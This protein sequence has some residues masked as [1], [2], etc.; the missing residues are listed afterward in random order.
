MKK[1]L[2]TQRCLFKS[3]VH[4]PWS[5]VLFFLLAPGPLFAKNLIPAL[6]QEGLPKWEQPK[7]EKQE[8]PNGF[9]FYTL[10]DHALPLFRATLFIETG[11]A[12]APYQKSG[13]ADLTSTLLVTGGTRTKEPRALDEWVEER[14]ITV[15]SG[16]GRELTTLH[17]S[18]LAHQ[19][20]DA[21]EILREVCLEPRFDAKRFDLAKR[22]FLEE[23]RRE[24]DHPNS[25]LSR[26]FQT[27]LYGKKHPWGHLPTPRSLR[28]IKREDL[29][30]FYEKYFHPNRM[31]LTVAGDFSPSQVKKWAVENFQE[32]KKTEIP[33]SEW[34]I[35]PFKNKPRTQKIRKK[36]NQVF[37]EMGHWG[38][39]RHQEERYAYG[40]LQ[41][42]L[43]GDAFTSRL[44]KDIR[45]ARGLAYSVYSDWEATPARGHFKIHVETKAESAE[46]VRQAI[47][48]HL[49]RL[50]EKADITPEELEGAKE[51][52]LNQYI[53]WFDSPFEIVNTRA[54][55]DL[56]GFPR[57]YLEEYPEKIKGVTLEKL[58]ET[59]K[60][61]IE[62]KRLTFVTVSP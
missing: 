47:I 14:A 19:W 8:L 25:V 61:Y 35:E 54:K 12:Y 57:R 6:A 18:A 60:K 2:R 29:T 21:L 37:L 11:Q 5:T 27:A 58:K 10:T 28:R 26:A 39:T 48:E 20:K 9:R 24:E 45:T 49:N 16:T 56:L 43:G 38:L 13:L 55:L 40:L 53:F 15:W 1:G 32:L 7:V 44:G 52:L 46:E 50:H 51:A 41:Y 34:K 33:D 4:G 36:V 23:L 42:I 31:V 17:V 22:R 62:P 30:A 3:M 59:A